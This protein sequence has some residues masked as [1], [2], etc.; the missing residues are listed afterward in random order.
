MEYEYSPNSLKKKYEDFKWLKKN[1]SERIANGMM[2]FIGAIKD[3]EN[4]YDLKA[5]RQF[6]M[7]HKRNSLNE[8]YSVSLDKKSSR[9]RLMLQMLDNNNNILV[10]TNNEI[11]F[12]KSIKKIR[13]KEMSEHYDE[14]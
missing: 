11:E 6:Y 2:K 14:Y 13:I 3:S 4:A 12:L 5:L 8:Y 9:W 7:E 10:P 1:Y